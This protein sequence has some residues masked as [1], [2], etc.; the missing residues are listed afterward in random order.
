MKNLY[1]IVILLIF[2]QS[3]QDESKNNV[4]FDNLKLKEKKCQKYIDKN[5]FIKISELN[6]SELLS[7]L[8][9]KNE[10]KNELNLLTT[11]GQTKADWLTEKDLVI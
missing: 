11:I 7:E 9:V 6:L 10:Q 5:G 2:I 8:K 1:Y 4:I 3:C